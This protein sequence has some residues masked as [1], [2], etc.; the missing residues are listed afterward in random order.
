M[1]SVRD[2]ALERV[3]SLR[4]WEGHGKR[5]SNKP[6]PLLLGLGRY[7]RGGSR[8]MDFA[9]LDRPLRNRLVEFG[10]PRAVHHTEYPFWYLQADGMWEMTITQEESQRVAEARYPTKGGLL[11][12]RAGRISGSAVSRGPE[13]RA[14]PG[15][16]GAGGRR[17]SVSRLDRG[18]SARCRRPRSH[19]TT[20]AE[21]SRVPKPDPGRLRVQ[22]RDPRLR[23]PAGH[24]TDGS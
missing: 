21:G 20:H 23:C 4:V 17:A 13:R 16:A 6:L 5:A 3:K 15:S 24:G 12:E 11:R 10:H 8:L 7:S 2:W 19:Q 14:V 22:M 1:D 18:G 9:E